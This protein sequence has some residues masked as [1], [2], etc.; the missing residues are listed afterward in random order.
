MQLLDGSCSAREKVREMVIHEITPNTTMRRRYATRGRNSTTD[1]T[2]NDYKPRPKITP[3]RL[4]RFFSL[5]D[6]S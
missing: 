4:S 1:G 3:F 6:W 2:L 5:S